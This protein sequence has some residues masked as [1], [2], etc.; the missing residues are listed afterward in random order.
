MTRV[1]KMMGTPL[2]KSYS[3]DSIPASSINLHTLCLNACHGGSDVKALSC[4]IQQSFRTLIHLSLA[5]VV[6]T[7]HCNHTYFL[8]K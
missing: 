3:R 7:T 1:M 4:L 6:F 8:V 5:L 2:R